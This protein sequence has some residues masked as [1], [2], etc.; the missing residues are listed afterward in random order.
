MALDGITAVA[1]I[2]IASF[3]IDRIAGG[4]L[5]LLAFSREWDRRFPDPA[6]VSDPVH[7]SR[8]ERRRKLVYL[9]FAALVGT[10]LLIFY[11]PAQILAAVGYTSVDSTLDR[12]LTALILIGGADKISEAL[13]WGSQAHTVSP[14]AHPVEV[15]GKLILEEPKTTKAAEASHAPG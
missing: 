3:A 5:F 15:T 12:I 1:A 4:I 13:K 2:L 6:T 7:K 10:P 8:A 14:P 9:I 11:W